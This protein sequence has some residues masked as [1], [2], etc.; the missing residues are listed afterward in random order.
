MKFFQACLNNRIIVY[1]LFV[2][3]CLVGVFSIYT[4]KITPMPSTSVNDYFVTFSYPGAN[5]ETIQK[6]VVDQVS[7][8]L[9]GLED[10]QYIEAGAMDEN[11]YININFPDDMS[12]IDLL[13]AQMKIVQAV[14]SAGLPNAVPAPQVHH[15]AYRSKLITLDIISKKSSVFEMNNFIKARLVPAFASLPGVILNHNSSDASVKISLDPVLLA[16]FDLQPSEV[17]QMVS[18]NYKSVPLGALLVDKSSYALN[19]KNNIKTLDDFRNIIIG[20]NHLGSDAA[21]GGSFTYIPTDTQASAIMGRPIYLKDVAKISFGS[22]SLEQSEFNSYNG[23]PS[24][25]FRIKTKNKADPFK[26]SAAV[27]KFL[28]KNDGHYPDGMQIKLVFDESNDMAAS[29]YE[30]IFTIVLACILVLIVALVFLGRFKITIVPIATIPVC[31]LGAIVVLNFCGFTLNIM[32]LLAMVIAVGLVVDDAIVVVENITRY[33]ELGHSKMEAIVHGTANIS[34]TIVG[35]TL[36]LLAVYLPIVFASGYLAAF[37]K[38]FSL[39]LAAAVFISGIAALTLTPVISASLLSDSK[40]NRYQTAFEKILHKIIGGYHAFLKFL[41]DFPKIALLVIVILVFLGGMQ[42]WKL[43]KR[44]APP[45]PNGKVG[46][47]IMGGTKDNIDTLKQKMSKFDKFYK[48][49]RVKYHSLSIMEDDQT[50]IL[51]ASSEIQYKTDYL[52]STPDIA[53]NITKFIKANKIQSASSS[54]MTQFGGGR[55]GDVIFSLY[56]GSEISQVNKEAS[57]IQDLLK[58]S[59]IF[60]MVFANIEKPQKQLSFEIDDVKAF[61]L[62]ITRESILQTLST[63]YGGSQLQ[64]YFSIDGLNVPVWIKMRDSVLTNPGS[65][66]NILIKSPETNTQFPINTFVKI[67]MV[68]KPKRIGSFNHQPSVMMFANLNKGHSMGEAINYIDSV[69]QKHAPQL[70][71]YYMG[72]AQQYIKGN[73]QTIWIAILGI[74]CVYF[75]LV[76]IFRSLLDPFIIMLT[77]PF[78]VVGGALSLYLIGANGSINI[79]SSLGFITLVGLITKHGVLIVQFANDELKK[80]QT[81]R[82]AVLLATH[83]RFRPVIMTTLAMVLGTLPLVL[84]SGMMYMSRQNLGIV[85]MGG[86]IIGT[87]F[88]LFIVPLAYALLKKAEHVKY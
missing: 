43:P 21:S 84:S 29:I 74:A 62:S 48:D 81:V 6:Q 30:V 36:T 33:I 88:S 24:A 26:I 23:V 10:V 38:P 69:I 20:Y 73:A 32:T 41:L 53:S 85:I 82:E 56:G 59:P 70:Q 39:T 4:A 1:I 11:G 52:K 44:I 2:A 45:D 66:N 15:A 64:D 37:I 68:A 67:N 18:N 80:G 12:D 25:S 61:S 57:Q 75:L 51:T 54:V 28:Q 7:R 22:R 83:H 9:E 8:R 50:H 72:S 3:A 65:I 76:I 5:A 58:G 31:L 35:I 77:V 27:T 16:K 40:P 19:Q 63:F 55:G 34:L 78:T 46:I 13:Q 86:L 87:F 17:Y 60:S 47:S 49:P 42:A 79:F 71:H 14:S